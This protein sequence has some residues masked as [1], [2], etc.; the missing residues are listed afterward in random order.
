MTSNTIAPQ[1]KLIDA[2][3]NVDRLENNLASRFSLH[4]FVEFFNYNYTDQDD[5]KF[6]TRVKLYWVFSH[7]C[8][9][10]IVGLEAIYMDNV[11]IGYRY[12]AHRKSSTE[13]KFLSKELM[14]QLRTF[15]GDCISTDINDWASDIISEEEL[16]KEILIK[17][18]C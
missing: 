18:W 12:L 5:E 7:Y 11:L 13:H 9:D 4:T 3:R 6:E 14:E 17:N 10:T 1:V 8:T 15:V 2:L 16:Q